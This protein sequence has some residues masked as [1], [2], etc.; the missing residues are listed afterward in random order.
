M[1]N[2]IESI[3]SDLDSYVSMQS[4]ALDSMSNQVDIVKS[5]ISLAK[6]NAGLE[7]FDGLRNAVPI[8]MPMNIQVTKA[9][10][11]VVDEEQQ[12][13]NQLTESTSNSRLTMEERMSK[14]DNIG[15]CIVKEV[16]K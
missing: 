3:A 1:G 15:Y 6:S 8:P 4:N 14:F 5:R 2:D 11:E 7:K 9:V 12:V 10:E 13:V 16:S